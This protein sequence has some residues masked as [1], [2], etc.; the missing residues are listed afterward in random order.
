VKTAKIGKLKFY[1]RNDSTDGGA[2][3]HI[4][5]QTYYLFV[6]DLKHKSF[7]V[8][9]D[10]GAHIG[11]FCIVTAS[12]SE[13][14]RVFAIEPCKENFEILKKNISLNKLKNVFASNIALSDSNGEEILF[15][16]KVGNI[17]HSL[18][19]RSLEGEVV[20]TKTLSRFFSE[21]NIEYCDFLKLNCEG[22]EFKIILSTPKV[23][24]EKIKFM[25]L[26]YHKDFAEDCSEKDLKEHLEKAG[27]FI[28]VI[29]KKKD[30]GRI[31]ALNKKF[32][33]KKDFLKVKVN[34]FTFFVKHLLLILSKKAG[35]VRQEKF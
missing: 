20:E 24:L 4:L 29:N 33:S 11:T 18:T 34:S 14:T 8:I 1:Y 12:K 35:F 9:V 10:V 13:K 7:D 16:S 15:H 30:R 2:L 32:Y 27:F 5:D 6:P 31:I 3:T 26:L 23:F 19:M 25:L 28:E 22:S 17:A 21:N